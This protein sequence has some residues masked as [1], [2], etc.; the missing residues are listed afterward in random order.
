MVLTG[1]WVLFRN[2]WNIHYL[3][4]FQRSCFL[5]LWMKRTH[6]LKVLKYISTLKHVCVH[7]MWF[8]PIFVV[9]LEVFS[10]L[11]SLP[12]HEITEKVQTEVYC[13]NIPCHLT[14]AVT[15]WPLFLLPFGRPLG[16]LGAGD[17]TDSWWIQVHFILLHDM[18]YTC[19]C[20]C[21]EHA[22]VWP[23]VVC[24][25]VLCCV[26]EPVTPFDSLQSPPH[27]SWPQNSTY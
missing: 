8:L 10:L 23:V 6:K 26:W 21:S 17:S 2:Q 14:L 12:A 24:E 25:V 27:P 19:V 7:V 3:L 16:R 13:K 22:C 5:W 9:F 15:R 11:S 4:F 18:T 20:V 1:H